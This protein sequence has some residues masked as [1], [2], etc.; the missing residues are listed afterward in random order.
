LIR[1]AD[2]IGGESSF[3]DWR[4]QSYPP[5]TANDPA[6]IGASFALSTNVLH[7]VLLETVSELLLEVQSPEAATW[8]ARATALRGA[9][10]RHFDNPGGRPGRVFA[11]DLGSRPSGPA[12]RLGH[13]PLCLGRLGVGP[14]RRLVGPAFFA[15]WDRR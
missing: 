9:I 5:W 6:Q 13:R 2:F 8:S 3:L 15:V 14:R 4:E 11:V 1:S 12:R 7:L 10:G